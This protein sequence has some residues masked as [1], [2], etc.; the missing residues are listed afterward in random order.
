MK[1]RKKKE[2]KQIGRSGRKKLVNE[3][4]LYMDKKI[5]ELQ[6]RIKELEKEMK[7][8]KAGK[9]K[10]ILKKVRKKLVPQKV[11]YSWKAPAIV[12]VQRE[13]AWFLKVSIVALLLI[14]FFAFLQDF[15]VILVICMTVLIT[16]LL[17][18]IPPQEVD[19]KVTNKGIKSIGDL[20][21][22]KDLSKFWV[23]EKYNQ[24]IV[25]VHT[26]LRY[27]SRIVMIVSKEDELKVVKL[28]LEQMDYKEL[29]KKQGLLSRISDGE[30][31]DQEHYIS[32]LRKRKGKGK[33][34]SKK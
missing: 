4:V 30:M 19:H 2:A 13:K 23:A 33:K 18:S 31:V 15:I 9:G 27:P 14:L 1:K 26:K 29:D 34:V 24:K 25:Y 8:T 5:K 6:K 7:Q 32:L 10:K 17:A 28:L 11:L 3:I 20:Y 21:K 12:F 22:W 16:F